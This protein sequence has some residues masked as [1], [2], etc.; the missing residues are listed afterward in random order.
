MAKTVIRDAD[1][2]PFSK[3]KPAEKFRFVMGEYPIMNSSCE[4]EWTFHDVHKYRFDFAWP[5]S[6]V[7]VE[8]DGFGFGHQAQQQMAA[9]NE[10]ANLAVVCGWRVLR[11]NSRQLGSR[12]GVADAVA[13]T[14]GLLCDV[15]TT[16]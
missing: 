2:K 4:P 13:L 5:Q 1:G 11:F 6:W 14:W 10:K 9:D 15:D 7:A 12:Q 16:C 8:I 3:W